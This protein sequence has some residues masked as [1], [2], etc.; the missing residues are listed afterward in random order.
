MKFQE[1]PDQE[2]EQPEPT[3]PEEDQESSSTFLV[4]FL[5]INENEVEMVVL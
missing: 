5:D 2:E 1:K 3:Q 4:K